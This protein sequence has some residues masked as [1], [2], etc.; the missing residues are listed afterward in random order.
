MVFATAS[1]YPRMTARDNIA[2]GLKRRGFGKA[3][4][5]KCVE[6][7]ANILTI[8]QLLERKPDMLSFAQRQRIVI[9]RALVRQPKVFLF[10]DVLS[11]LDKS[12]RA[13]LSREIKKLHER[14]QTTMI[15]ATADGREAMNLADSI[16]LLNGG[17]PQ[18]IGPAHVLYHEPAN[19]FVAKFSVTRR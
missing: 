8:G 3:E 1:L 2:F 12:S 17:V 4:I 16:V 7:A 19:M 5:K 6:D 14:L 11:N 9:A 13:E 15:F 10:D 18:Q